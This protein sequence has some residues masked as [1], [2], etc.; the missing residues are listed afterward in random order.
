MVGGGGNSLVFGPVPSRRLGR[1][2]GVNNIPA[3]TCSYSCVYCQL[4]RTTR[5]SIERRKFY[6]PREIYLR[7]AERLSLIKE[8]GEKVDYVTFVPDGEPTLDV[9]LGHEI[10]LLK[11]LGVK[12]AVLTNASLMS[13]EDVRLDLMGADL[14]SV[15]I[16]SLHVKTWKRVN[17]PHPSL[18]LDKIIEGLKS[19]SKEYKGMLITETMMIEGVDYLNELKLLEEILKDLK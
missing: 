16:D 12:V 9:N 2:L 15:K 3:K 10:R 18:V 7:V 17:R 5:L 8:K 4:G 13:R 14:V 11:S 1:S 19:F 6:P